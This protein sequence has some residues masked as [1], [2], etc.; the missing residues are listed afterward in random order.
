MEDGRKKVLI[1]DDEPG[2]RDSLRLLLKNQYEVEVAEDGSQALSVLGAFHPDLILLDLIM[3][4]I[5]GMETLRQVRER[6]PK[7]T[8][9]YFKRFKYG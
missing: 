8:C 5:D 3:P 7:N 4:R 1:V 9:R 2:V 6:S